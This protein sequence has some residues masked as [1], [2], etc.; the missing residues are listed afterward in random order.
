VA[1][2]L[3]RFG[4]ALGPRPFVGDAA[5]NQRWMDTHLYTRQH[6]AERD[7]VALGARREAV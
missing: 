1:D 6:H 7:L 2:I 3:D 5:V 4:Q